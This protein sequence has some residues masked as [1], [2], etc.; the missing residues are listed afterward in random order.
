M[1]LGVMLAGTAITMWSTGRLTGSGPK[2][3]AQ[4]KEWRKQGNRPFSVTWTDDTGE[5]QFFELSPYDPISMPLI[6]VADAA[7]LM[8]SGHLREDE[9]NGLA[10]PR[11][12]CFRST[13]R[14]ANNSIINARNRSAEALFSPN[15]V[16]DVRQRHPPG[17]AWDI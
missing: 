14:K 3:P 15:Q 6:L 7:A 5:R 11:T 4:A 17:R 8:N 16:V 13:H 10:I 2:D 1:M 12:I 9:V